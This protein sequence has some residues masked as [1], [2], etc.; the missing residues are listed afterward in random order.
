MFPL[1]LTTA[2]VVP[3]SDFFTV[4]SV[5]TVNAP[6]KFVVPV[7][8]ILP[9]TVKL[10]AKGK[11]LEVSAIAVPILVIDVHF[12]SPLPAPKSS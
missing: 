9:P 10:P 1:D 2:N 12:A 5:L 7:T 3:P 8:V 4:R 11:V 6:V